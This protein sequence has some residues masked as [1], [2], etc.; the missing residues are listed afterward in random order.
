MWK[1]H[2]SDLVLQVSEIDV[3]VVFNVLD[4]S[5]KFSVRSCVKETKASHLAQVISKGIGSGGGHLTKA[6][7]F[8]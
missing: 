7:G 5:I 4:F 3:C 8:H 6:G 1:R 2:I